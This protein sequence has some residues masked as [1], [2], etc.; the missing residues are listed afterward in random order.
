[1]APDRIWALR[2]LLITC[3]LASMLLLLRLLRRLGMP[4]ARVAVYAWAPLPIFE[5]AQAAHIDGAFLPLVLGAVLA[6]MAGGPGLTGALLGAATLIKLYPAIL[7]PAL[8]QRKAWR[9]PL[10][11][12]G[13]VALAYLPYAWGIGGKAVG[14]LPTYFQRSEDFNVGLRALLTEGIGLRGDAAR[15][16]AMGVLAAALAVAVLAI[17]R[18]RSETPLGVARG[19]GMAVGAYLLLVPSSLHPWYVVWLIPFLPFLTGAGWWWLSGAVA[20]SYLAYAS[21]PAQVPLWA[22]YLEW[23][24]AYV[25]VLVG[26]G[27]SGR[28]ALRAA[29]AISRAKLPSSSP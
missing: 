24:P 14:F 4:E 12:L 21:D 27:A 11:F 25:L 8:W 17:S 23:V 20:L 9:L 29:A 22:R 28:S 16:A 15:G 3:D 6:R 26:L 10:V 18:R 7:L 1:V 13:T 2:L 19:V 5:F